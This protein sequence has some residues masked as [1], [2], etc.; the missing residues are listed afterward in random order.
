MGDLMFL[1]IGLIPVGIIVAIVF[2]GY[3]WKQ[4]R[5]EVYAGTV[6]IG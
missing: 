3:T 5:K 2:F 6:G 4:K 1:L